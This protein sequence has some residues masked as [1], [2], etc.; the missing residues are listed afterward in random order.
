MLV[1]IVFRDLLNV[2]CKAS[3]HH[4]DLNGGDLFTEIYVEGVGIY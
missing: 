1:E 4:V 3:V 2:Y